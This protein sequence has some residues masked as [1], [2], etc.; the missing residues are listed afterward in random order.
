MK[1]YTPGVC[2]SLIY[3]YLHEFKGEVTVIKEGCLGLGTV[4][5][6]AEGMKYVVIRE[7][8]Q[9]SWSSTHTIRMYN[10]LP[11]KY[12]CEVLHTPQKHKIKNKDI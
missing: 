5:L 4:L 1:H 2:E 10:K 7:R 6:S 12:N 3:K 8:F 9:T 11:K